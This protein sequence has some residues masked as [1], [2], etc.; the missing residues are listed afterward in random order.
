[1][2]IA[3][4]N[5]TIY[6]F[7]KGGAEK[8][9]WEIAKRLAQRGHEIHLF[10]MRYWEGD[11]VFIKEN[12]YLHGV[13]DV[14]ELYID[15]R[16]SI[17]EA[18]YFACK[19]LKPLLKE[20]FDVI[21]CSNFP[22]FPCF[23]AKIHSLTKGSVLVITWL[24]VWDNY[25]FEY[26]GKM[27]RVGRLIE[28]LTARLSNNIIAISEITK[29]RLLS[30]G[31]KGKIKVMPNGMDFTEITNATASVI[32]SQS[33][34]LFAGRL[35]ADK[36][37]DVLIK[38]IGL[39]A[40]DN[41]DISCLI[42]GEGPERKRLENMVHD[43]GLKNNVQFLGFLGSSEEVFAYMKSSKVFAFP[44]TREGFGIVV[45]EAN[46]CGLPVITTNHPQNAARDLVID[47]RTGFLCNLDESDL[48][49]KISTALTKRQDISSSCIEFSQLY[50]W[51]KIVDMFEQYYTSLLGKNSAGNQTG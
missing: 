42:I 20:E 19:L 30:V 23:T 17:K 44:S 34:I 43:A 35:I 2:K 1:M 46:A 38:A 27:G 47:G 14:Q 25:W 21:D 9:V 13:C 49:T 5:D 48:A 45:T 7:S 29:Q 41:P 16:R 32:G 28:R 51:N 10:G 39:I 37:I 36:N 40:R 8:R 24:E 6:P 22:Y 31:A 11:A 50:E 26:L 18:I 3:F 12:V 15:G 33:D 4:V